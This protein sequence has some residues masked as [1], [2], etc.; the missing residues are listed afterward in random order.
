MGR[1]GFAAF[2]LFVAIASVD[3]AFSRSPLWG[4][5]ALPTSPEAQQI[6]QQ[7]LLERPD[8][9]G[10]FVG[11][12]IRRVNRHGHPLPVPGESTA[13]SGGASFGRW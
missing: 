3:V 12:T 4:S 1:L 6:R 10:H 8:R 5:F 11:N 13:P 2:A 7:P 9:P